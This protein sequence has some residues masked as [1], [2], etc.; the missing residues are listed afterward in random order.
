MKK[1]L[2]V[3]LLML[4]YSCKKENVIEELVDVFPLQD[5]LLINYSFDNFETNILDSSGNQFDGKSFGV[6]YDVDRFGKINRA[7]SFNGDYS[8]VDLPN[9]SQLKPQLPVS[10]S[11]WVKFKDLSIDKTT[12]FTTD[13][14]QNKHTGVFTSINQS[15]QSIAVGF[16][17]GNYASSNSRRSKYGETIIKK[18]TWY[19]ITYVLISSTNINI[20]VKEYNTTGD[21]SND[22]GVY[23]GVGGNEIGYG[24]IQGSIGRNDIH[25]SLDPYY[26]EGSLDD[27][28]MWNKALSYEEVKELYN[29][30]V[31]E[32]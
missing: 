10:I 5:S 32:N 26:F 15:S 9:I 30:S 11:M 6:G 18:D 12:V 24:D 28:R 21:I 4:I 23:S 20:Y 14:T 1:S 25:S 27:F 31:L 19:F 2:Y 8:Y 29:F 16:G 22:N 7:A 17:D 13:Y 3:L